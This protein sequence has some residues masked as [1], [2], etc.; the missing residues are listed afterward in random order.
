METTRANLLWQ[1]AD[2]RPEPEKDAQFEMLCRTL[3]ELYR[4]CLGLFVFCYTDKCWSK[5]SLEGRAIKQAEESYRLVLSVRISRYSP[6]E[7]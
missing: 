4:T 6:G 7:N 5:S 3:E 1:A 2:V